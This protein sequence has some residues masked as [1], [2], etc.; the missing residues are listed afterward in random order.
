MLWLWQGSTPSTSLKLILILNTK[1]RLSFISTEAAAAL[2]NTKHFSTLRAA[3]PRLSAVALEPI[4]S[5]R[6]WHKRAST[7]RFP[8]CT[9]VLTSNLSICKY[10]KPSTYAHSKI[11]KSQQTKQLA[12]L[13]PQSRFEL[14]SSTALAQTLG[15]LCSLLSLC[16]SLLFPIQGSNARGWTK[17]EGVRCQTQI[18][19]WSTLVTESHGVL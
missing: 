19:R 13:F 17:S 5:D 8:N 16:F 1:D 7:S 3:R 15:Y 14:L 18:K 4:F 6:H 11:R 2:N 12:A 10:E 9:L